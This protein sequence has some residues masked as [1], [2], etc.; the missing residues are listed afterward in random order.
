MKKVITYGTFDLFHEGHKNILRR[1]KELG[2]YLVVGVTSENYDKQ[3]G[4]LNVQQ[5]VVE[6]I[7]NVKNSG[8]ADQVIV[9]EYFGQKIEDIK[10]Y[11]IDTFVIGSDWKG[12]FDYLKEYCEVVY[13]PRTEGV[14]STQLRNQNRGILKLGCVGTGRIAH[15]MLAESKFVSGLSLDYIYDRNMDKAHIFADENDLTFYTDNYD[16]LL[17]MVDAVY[18]AIPHPFHYEYTRKALEAGKHVIC[19]KPFTLNYA[20]SRELYDMAHEK[21]L[22]LYEAIKTAYVPAFKRL[23]AIAKSG[24]IGQIKDVDATFTKLIDDRGLREF[25]PAQGGGS[26]NELATYPLIAIFKL[27]GCDYKNVMYY[28]Y[29]GDSEVDLY[30]KIVL[31]YKDAVATANVGIGVKKEGSLVVSGTKG[32]IYVPAPWWKTDYFEVRF[33][34]PANN[35]KHY[36][37]FEGDGLRY[38]LSEFL[39]SIVNKTSNISLSEDES[40]TI[41]KVLEQYKEQE[42]VKKI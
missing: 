14:S 3:R 18:I 26:L 9:E 20:Q 39:N 13:L 34:N 22:V 2:D 32:Y 23:Q 12:K 21:G 10:K 36:F 31:E 42:K 25:N 30:T 5:S 19:E 24:V 6:R 11:N 4:K 37:Q 16:E 27:L 35:Q 40:C 29:V 28:S 38:E 41:S 7:E 1:A 33:E 15:R 17:Q 8:Y